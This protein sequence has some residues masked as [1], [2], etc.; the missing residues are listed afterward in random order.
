VALALGMP[1]T[2]S[3]AAD[4]VMTEA[5]R[6]GV[7]TPISLVDGSGLSP[8][9]RITPQALVRLLTAAA[10]PAHGRLRAAITGLPVAGFSGTLAAGGSVF[11]SA[12]PAALGVVRAKTGNLT[13][14]AA[15][16]GIA[17]AANGQLLAFAVMADQ[18]AQGGLDT[19]GARMA[20]VATTLAACGC[21]S[22]G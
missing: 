7:T 6:L 14:V 9:D 18:L 17:Y 15:L 16:A 4:A 21:H 13:T 8:R 11:G 12:G 5:H 10:S 22:S 3:G 1:A 2:F 19:A 20:K